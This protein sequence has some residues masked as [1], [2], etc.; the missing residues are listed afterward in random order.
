MGKDERVNIAH[1]KV[2]WK[3]RIS[4]LS[5]FS[6]FTATIT[7]MVVFSREG[8]ILTTDFRYPPVPLTIRYRLPFLLDLFS[9]LYGFLAFNQITQ[10]IKIV[11][12]CLFCPIANFLR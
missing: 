8:F 1:S 7:T 6:Y 2:V 9:A 5:E 4:H 3:Y 10:I 12:S 11:V